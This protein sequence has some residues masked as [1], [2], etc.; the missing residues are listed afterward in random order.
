LD[1]LVFKSVPNAEYAL[2][3]PEQATHASAVMNHA[4]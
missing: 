4:D 2:A 3:K 1:I